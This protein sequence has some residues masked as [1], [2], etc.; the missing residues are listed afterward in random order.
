MITV[1]LADDHQMVRQGLRAILEVDPEFSI[2]AESTNGIETVEKVGRLK[3]D[4]LIQDWVM[5]N[6]CGAE[7]TRE[8]KVYSPNTQVLILSMHA[9]E[10]YVSEALRSGAM[11]Y[12]LKNNSASE[13]KQAIR[14]IKNGRRYLGSPL[15]EKAIDIYIRKSQPVEV[16]PYETL[17]TRE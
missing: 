14:E 2:V 7:L 12:L 1:M 4:I 15:S 16:D 9:N 11:G 6:L 5:P 17:T 10:V 8:V 13:L 3:P